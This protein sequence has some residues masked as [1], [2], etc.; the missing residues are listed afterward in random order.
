MRTPR[1]R[2]KILDAVLVLVFCMVLLVA[3]FVSYVSKKEEV[4]DQIQNNLETEESLEK[5]LKDVSRY[6]LLIMLS[7]VGKLK[8]SLTYN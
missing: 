3:V 8:H 7:N 4:T 5:R 2:L 6:L 1:F